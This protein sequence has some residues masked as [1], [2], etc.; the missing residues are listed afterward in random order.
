[1]ARIPARRRRRKCGISEVKRR[2]ALGKV[3]LLRKLETP[4]VNQAQSMAGPIQWV[5]QMCPWFRPFLGGLCAFFE[6]R[7]RFAENWQNIA[8]YELKS[9]NCF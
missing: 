8:Y 7:K 3:Q 1:M 2:F 6:N 4:T 5:S 9:G